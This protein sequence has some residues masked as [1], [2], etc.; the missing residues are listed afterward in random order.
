MKSCKTA[1]KHLS[2]MGKELEHIGSV[3][4]VGNLPK[5]LEEAEEAKTEVEA[6]ILERVKHQGTFSKIKSNS[7]SNLFLILECTTSRNF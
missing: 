4:N 5:K 3:T 7:N 1:T 6:L 2:E